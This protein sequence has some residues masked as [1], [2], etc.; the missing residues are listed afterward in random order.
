MIYIRA[1]VIA[2]IQLNSLTFF[3]W[4]FMVTSTKSLIMCS[5]RSVFFIISPAIISEIDILRDI[6][7]GSRSDISGNPFPARVNPRPKKI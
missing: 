1:T 3:S 4:S 5:V 7:N 6:A 2:T